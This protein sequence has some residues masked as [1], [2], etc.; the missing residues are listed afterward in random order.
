[1]IFLVVCLVL[2]LSMSTSPVFADRGCSI[3]DVAGKWVFAT[4][5]GRQMAPMFPPEKDIT[6]IGTMNVGRDGSI[7]GVFDVTV[8]D[9]FFQPD[10]PYTGTMTINRDCTGTLEFVTGIDSAR[11]DSIVV[12]N[13]SEILGMSQ[14]PLNLWTYQVRRIA[15]AGRDRD[16]D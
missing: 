3:R 10:I 9:T 15:F 16:D 11:T 2:T 4:S 7:E 12:V 5:I 1:M 8:E 14:D 6:A 13:R